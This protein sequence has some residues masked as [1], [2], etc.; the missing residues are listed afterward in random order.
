[1]NAAAPCAETEAVVLVHG[2]RIR[3]RMSGAGDPVLL[4]N[5]LA[6]PMDSWARFSE[7]LPDRTIIAFDAPG[8][9]ASQSPAV[10]FS[11]RMLADVGA[12]VLDRFGFSTTDVIGFSHGGA[13]AQQF[14]ASYPTRVNRLALLA[15]SCG[16][17]SVPGRLDDM[18][19]L[20]FS[21]RFR[22]GHPKPDPRGLFWQ[23]AAISAWSSIPLLSSI[24]AP[25]LI[26]CGQHDRT[27]PPANSK[28][29]AD[30]IARARVV[31]VPG[32][33]DL[34]SPQLAP[35]VAGLVRGFLAE[36]S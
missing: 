6:R 36:R 21:R 13:V 1:V 17:G 24:C 5:G 35:V 15:T 16:L 23:I 4:M 10:Y 14:A 31:S 27:V 11:M 29:L 34:Q 19:R 32:G 30:R 8:V 22:P 2:I 9:G 26:L 7:G 25:T 20:I 12:A 18:A 33:H 28:V 3:A